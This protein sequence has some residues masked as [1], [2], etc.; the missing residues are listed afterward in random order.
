MVIISAE[1]YVRLGRMGRSLTDTLGELLL[2]IPKPDQKFERLFI[3]N[4]TS[5]P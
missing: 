1:E 4:R 2:E 3:S 5:V